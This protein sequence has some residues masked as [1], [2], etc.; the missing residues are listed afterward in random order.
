LKCS[1]S[2][3][4][5]NYYNDQIYIH[6]AEDAEVDMEALDII[7]Y[8][9]EPEESGD[10]DDGDRPDTR[11]EDGG[12]GNPIDEC[13]DNMNWLGYLLTYIRIE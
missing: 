1:V 13:L 8:S 10:D 7:P 6:K 9:Y 5:S 4:G 12:G 2:L 11:A 3:E